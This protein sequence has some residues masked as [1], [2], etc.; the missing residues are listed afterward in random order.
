MTSS[1]TLDPQHATPTKKSNTQPPDLPEKWTPA[2]AKSGSIHPVY[3]ESDV[4][5]DQYE[6]TNSEVH[7]LIDRFM[8]MELDLGMLDD[9][10]SVPDKAVPP[11]AIPFNGD[12]LFPRLADGDENLFYN[13]TTREW[14]EF[15]PH[16]DKTN[17]IMGY[18]TKL[19]QAVMLEPGCGTC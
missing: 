1:S 3:Q 16:N 7:E 11:D 6:R 19:L 13:N 18:L 8:E 9:E 17:P 14:K 15:P 4:K 10:R 2:V 5:L 12:E